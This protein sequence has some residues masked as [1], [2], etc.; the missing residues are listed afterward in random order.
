MRCLFLGDVVGRSGRD[1]VIRLVPLLRERFALD[2]VLVNGDNA[3][4]G[5][6][7]NAQICED[8]FKAGVD[9]ITGGDHIWDQN[10]VTPYLAR[11]KRLLRPHN[12]PT[13]CPGKGAELFTTSKGKKVAV[14]HL[15]GQVFHKE[16]A[17]CPFATAEE[18]LKS[19]ILGGNV[20][21]ILVDMHAEATSEK[22]AMGHFLDGRVSLVIGSHTHIPT[23]D[24]RILPGGTAYLTD[25]GMCGDYQSVIGF[26]KEAPL[27]SF[28]HK[29]RKIRLSPAQG[30]PSLGGA[31]LETANNGRAARF[32]PFLLGGVFGKGIEDI[33]F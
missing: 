10:D 5:F 23:A 1:E 19:L 26:E 18:V 27:T 28:L 22:N 32:V 15:L 2:F 31:L 16:N 9:C 7:I 3:A 33:A 13:L 30:Q 21:A 20:D 4:G 14:L 29:Y 12:F 6:G 24:G 11:E 8:F 25:A 17:N